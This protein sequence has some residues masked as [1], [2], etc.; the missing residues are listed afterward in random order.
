MKQLLLSVLALVLCTTSAWAQ[1]LNPGGGGGGGTGLGG[2]IIVSSIN[3][4]YLYAD[5]FPGSTM[6]AKLAAAENVCPATGCTIDASNIT[7]AQTWSTTLNLTK[8]T[9]LLLNGKISY[10]G[11]PLASGLIH[12]ADTGGSGDEISCA[13]GV[14][15]N[16]VWPPVPNM[17]G[18]ALTL[19]PANLL[20]QWQCYILTNPT[21]PVATVNITSIA[22]AG[23]PPVATVTATGTVPFTAGQGVRIAGVNPDY[24]NTFAI[25]QSVSGST[26]T[27]AANSSMPASGT[28]GTAATYMPVIDITYSTSNVNIHDL[29]FVAN[30]NTGSVIHE[31]GGNRIGLG[32]VNNHYNHNQ[33]I[34]TDG[35]GNQGFAVEI[36]SIKGLGE[37]TNQKE[38]SW[39]SIGGLAGC[40]FIDQSNIVVASLVGNECFFWNNA[41][42]LKLDCYQCVQTQNTDIHT[43]IWYG[44]LG[45]ADHPV[46]EVDSGYNINIENNDFELP[47][48]LQ[49]ANVDYLWIHQGSSLYIVNNAFLSTPPPNPNPNSGRYAINTDNTSSC[50]HLVID[51]NHSSGGETRF[52]NDPINATPPASGGFQGYLYYGHNEDKRLVPGAGQQVEPWV[53]QM[54]GSGNG[55]NYSTTSTTFVP[56]DTG[57]MQYD[58]WMPN[59]YIALVTGAADIYN[60]TAGQAGCLA[61]RDNVSGSVLNQKVMANTTF[62]EASV[63]Y[64]IP[65]NSQHYQLQLAYASCGGSGTTIVANQNTPSRPIFTVNLT[66]AGGN[67]N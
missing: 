64:I 54:T 3:N 46:L 38:I 40:Y 21:G 49:N 42:T 48:M 23:S 55:A 10:T 29:N 66:P 43:D 44:G 28:G 4:A 25:V 47:N 9:K 59:G 17:P 58:F 45:P 37:N 53:A 31:S 67:T 11:A 18:G 16:P 15:I 7:G 30:A 61:I 8:P 2:N 5:Q 1:Q 33:F 50:G 57:R 12:L 52:F 51:G 32:I 19:N 63:Q 13:K 26:F 27:F 35:I 39:N 34:N 65:G 62:S 60:S 14:G 41:P 56:I 20:Q 22:V 24:F 6:D 36:S